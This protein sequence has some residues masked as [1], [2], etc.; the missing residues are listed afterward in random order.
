[1]YIV[2]DTPTPTVT[3]KIPGRFHEDHVWR[4]CPGGTVIRTYKSGHLLVELDREAFDDLLSDARHYST[5][6]SDPEWFGLVSSARA[7]VKALAKVQR[8]EASVPVPFLFRNPDPW[9]DLAAVAAWYEADA[10]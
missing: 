1:L 5:D 10:G 2:T 4:D 6:Y 9:A 3:V 7:T 8:P